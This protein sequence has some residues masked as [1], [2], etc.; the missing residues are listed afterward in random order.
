MEI[1]DIAVVGAGPAGCMAAIQGSKNEKS[2]VLLEKN[3]AIGCKLLLTAQGRCNFTNTANLDVFLEKFGKKG[4]FY[5]DAFSNFSN[6][7]LM[8]FFQNKGLD[9][10]VEEE[11][12]VFPIT[13]KSK[14][15]VEILRNT[16]IKQ[17]VDIIYNFHLENL[18]K[19]SDL[20]YLYSTKK[21]IVRAYKVI[22]ATGGSSYKFT[23]S[24]GEGFSFAESLG[25]HIIHQKPGGVPLL[26]KEKWVHNLKGVSLDVG[27]IV[28]QGKKKRNIS[29]GS[30]LF[31]HF[32]ISGPVILDLSHDILE[33]M[34]EHE[35]LVLYLDLKP[36]IEIEDLNEQLIR[37]FQD[38]SKKSLKNY[39]K[40]HLPQSMVVPLL[41]IIYLDPQKKLNQITK[42][43]RLNL[44]EIL[45]KLPVTIS[46][47]TSLD[48]AMVTCS[49]ISKKEIDPRTMESK[50]VENLYFAGEII[51]GC[52][53]R[54]GYNLQQAFSTGFV[55]GK[56]AS[57][58]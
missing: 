20:F 27:V 3:D 44:L 30:L 46:G 57:V 43:E 53:L 24:S 45:K 51:A 7:D 49:G 56:C 32:G 58:N 11:G 34:D 25:H 28:D 14:S 19:N 48:Q 29:Y 26:V 17:N 47:Y 38:H 23:G 41:K 16:L 42:K 2:V 55:A 1:F 22:L 4:S 39:L 5:R 37:D 15:I 10:K 6:K 52:G 12:R 8:K 31:T 35:D 21:Q 40:H 9:Y 50:L 33:L 54:G 18:E 36:K 13:E